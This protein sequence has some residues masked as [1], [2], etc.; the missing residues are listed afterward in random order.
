MATEHQYRPLDVSRNEIR[1]VRLAPSRYPMAKAF[2]SFIHLS[3]DDN[4]RFEALSYTWG[5]ANLKRSISLDGREFVVTRNLDIALRHL[6][7]IQ[8]ERYLWID[9]LCIN[10]HDYIE[11]NQQVSKMGQIYQT[12]A[13]VV[14]WLGLASDNSDVGIDLS[15]EACTKRLEMQAW[16]FEVMKNPGR[17]E[18]WKAAL[19]LFERDY[20]RRVWIIQE[21]FF[22]KSLI[23]RCGFRCIRWSDFIFPYFSLLNAYQLVFGQEDPVAVL[24]KNISLTITFA[25]LQNRITL[26]VYIEQ[27][28]KNAENP[29]VKHREPLFQLLMFT[30]NSLSSNPR[31]K[32]YGIAG[33]A[34]QYDD[35]RALKIDYRLSARRVYI[36][37]ARILIERNKGCLPGPVGIICASKPHLSDGSLPSWVPDWSAP[38]DRNSYAGIGTESA[39]FYANGTSPPE[40]N[41]KIE[42]DV[43]IVRGIKIN[44]IDHLGAMPLHKIE[45]GTKMNP[46]DLMRYASGPNSPDSVFFAA[47]RLATSTSRDMPHST[48]PLETRTEEF[49][50]TLI[51]NH[52][53]PSLINGPELLPDNIVSEP[54]SED[55]MQKFC[56]EVISRVAPG[57]TV[58]KY[59]LGIEYAAHRKLL[60]MAI[61]NLRKYRFCVSS[62]GSFVMGPPSVLK[63]DLVCILFGCNMPVILRETDVNR[64]VFVGE[65]YVHGIMDGEAIEG[66]RAGKYKV[67]EFRIY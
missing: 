45:L 61:N 40:P 10:Q 62:D 58:V 59:M 43:L 11:R 57:E 2:C 8:D 20:W 13:K 7:Y 60:N 44:T 35:Y 28:R 37:T 55:T 47:R 30:R 23:V 33:M 39:L 27:C 24:G 66:M 34:I 42:S 48:R 22:A 41:F 19:N 67:K 4:I 15:L 49:T 26:P 1:V 63:G 14:V 52:G 18:H 25:N 46:L 53:M 54:L 21:I 5:D 9:A 29:K 51:L 65:C 3:L 32:V 50:R 12:A 16:M 38:L 17:A 64:Y 36:E 31:D 56:R 6:R